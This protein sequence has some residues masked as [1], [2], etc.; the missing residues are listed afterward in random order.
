MLLE[1]VLSLLPQ[2]MGLSF[3]VYR[4]DLL[5]TKYHIWFILILFWISFFFLELTGKWHYHFAFFV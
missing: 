4:L 5:S 2:A 1:D 3:Q